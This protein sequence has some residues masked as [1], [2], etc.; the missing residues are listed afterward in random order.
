MLLE[1]LPEK[2]K[3]CHG[4]KKHK[5]NVTVALFVDAAGDKE[6]PI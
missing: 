3:A 1:T 5:L 6:K 2:G 4:G